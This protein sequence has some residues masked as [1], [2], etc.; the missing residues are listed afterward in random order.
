MAQCD[1]REMGRPRR[2]A[3]RPFADPRELHGAAKDLGVC[4]RA[5]S[6]L[7]VVRLN[8]LCV[9]C[10][11]LLT[12]EATK[13][14]IAGNDFDENGEGEYSGAEH[15]QYSTKQTWRGR[16]SRERG[17][18]R[19]SIDPLSLGAPKPASAAKLTAYEYVDQM[20]ARVT[21]NRGGPTRQNSKF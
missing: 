10:R 4:H 7:A 1:H 19:A 11:R 8:I 15:C 3:G 17:E 13:E 16:R 20:R 12:Y 6:V 14:L 9:K 21:L 2:T 18:R 5:G